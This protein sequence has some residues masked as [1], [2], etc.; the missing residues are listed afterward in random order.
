MKGL[1]K[2]LDKIKP[3]FRKGG[4]FEKLES[5]FDAFETFLYVPDTV[6]SSGSHIRDFMDMKRTM[7]VVVLALVPALLFG[8]WNTGYQ[9]FLATGTDVTFW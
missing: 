1:R 9:H 8:M 7:S 2:Y 6:T 4:K 5:T 3:Q